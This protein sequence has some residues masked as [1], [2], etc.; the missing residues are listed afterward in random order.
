MLKAFEENPRKPL[1]CA[2]PVS[3]SL[4]PWQ[5]KWWIFH[6]YNVASATTVDHGG[7]MEELTKWREAFG[8]H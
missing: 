8:G 1:L 4:C 5:A 7:K 6:Q 3:T 2:K